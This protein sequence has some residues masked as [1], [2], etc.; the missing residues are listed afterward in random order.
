MNVSDNAFDKKSRRYLYLVRTARLWNN[1][2]QVLSKTNRHGIRDWYVLCFQDI[3]EGDLSAVEEFDRRD[4]PSAHRRVHNHVSISL[5]YIYTLIN[6]LHIK[7]LVWFMVVFGADCQLYF[8]QDNDC[9]LVWFMVFNPTF[10]NISG[11]SRRSVLLEEETGVPREN[12]RPVA[13]N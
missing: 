9:W 5:C 6:L 13:S 4:I 7:S 10:N 1:F 3:Y 2:H 11:I 8:A 12:H